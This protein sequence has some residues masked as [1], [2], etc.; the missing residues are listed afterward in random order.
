MRVEGR[1]TSVSW[2]PTEAMNGMMRVPLDLGIGHYD[3]PPPNRLGGEDDLEDW[4]ANDR[5]RFAN[6][7]RAAIEVEDG[8]IVD[9]EHLGGGVIGATTMRIVRSS[10]TIPAVSFPDI[11]DIERRDTS[12]TFVQ[13]AGGRTGAPLPRKVSKPPFVRLVAPTAWTTLA[14]TLHA[15]G[16]VEHEVRSVSPFPRHW[17]YDDSGQLVEKSGIISYD[18][19]ARVQ[20]PDETPWRGGTDRGALVT[21]VES[22]LEHQLSA[23]I[24]QKDQNP[25]IENHPVGTKLVEQGDWGASVYLLLDGIVSVDVDGG[26]VAEIGPGAVFGERAALEGGTRT[27]TL[28]ALTPV[29]VAHVLPEQIDRSALAQLADQHRRENEAS[30]PTT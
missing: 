16:R 26:V 10:L 14:L 8:R 20:N 23:L 25:T 17:I 3:Q 19:W 4:R 30:A 5:F 18:D 15:D 24:M 2:I 12:V 21:K 28:T 22:A 11:T 7:L 27:A 13:T 6:H 1:V 9:A 29:R